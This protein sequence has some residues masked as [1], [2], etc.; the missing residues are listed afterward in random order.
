[1]GI[2]TWF[3]GRNLGHARQAVVGLGV[4]PVPGD[5]YT[6]IR[7][8]LSELELLM[9]VAPVAAVT[10]PS[11]EVPH[12]EGKYGIEANPEADLEWHDEDEV[13]AQ[14]G[15]TYEIR[16]TLGDA[17]RH[18][19]GFAPVFWMVSR[20]PMSVDEW[21]TDWVVPLMRLASLA[22][23]RPQE[24]GW[25][26]VET[27]PLGAAPYERGHKRGVV[28][29]SGIHQDPHE[30]RDDPNW[31]EPE[32]RPLFTLKA[33]PRSLPSLVRTWRALELD[34]NPFVE[35]YTQALFQLDLPPRARFLYLVQALEGLHGHEN[36]ES[37]ASASEAYVARRNDALSAVA[38]ADLDSDIARFIRDSWSKR[39]TDSLDRR[40]RDLIRELPG[41]VQQE[42]APPPDGELVLQLMA[43][44]E[45]SLEGQ[46]R[47]LRNQLS[48]GSRNYDNW[49]LR[50][51]VQVVET[52]CR[53]HALRLLGFD[54]QAI[55]HG[56]SASA[57]PPDP[58]RDGM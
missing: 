22:T 6:R 31:R 47:L 4:A 32:R 13:V 19:V 21:I 27:R 29:G 53:A 56:L 39:P 9:G 43:A 28:F 48:H 46:L 8:Q 20:R 3:P 42:L 18:E 2:S 35:L 51:M 36:L 14:F 41:N 52:L 25:L 57:P 38:D 12:L 17:Y 16:T 26:V 58:R 1:M 37:D 34:D 45:T 5:A 30:A 10:Y 54:P 50:P 40:L 49:D 33:L 7:F 44:G 55:E 15:C 24:I 23:R 11:D